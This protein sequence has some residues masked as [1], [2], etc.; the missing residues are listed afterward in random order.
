MVLFTP[1]AANPRK[2]MEEQK[3]CFRQKRI[4]LGL[5][6]TNSIPYMCWTSN[7]VQFEK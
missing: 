1:A 3:E 4:L 2:H 7:Y 6:M 5:G